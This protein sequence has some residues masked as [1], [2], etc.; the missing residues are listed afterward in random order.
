MRKKKTREY[1]RNKS[2]TLAKKIARHMANFKCA[3][4]GRGEPQLRTHGSHIFS[5]GVYKNMS[6]DID[7]ILCLCAGH[8]AIIP[9][10]NP[11]SWNW[12]AYPDQ[13]WEWFMAEYPELYQQ[14]K[15]RT[16]KIYKIDFEKKHERLKH[17]YKKLLSSPHHKDSIT[18]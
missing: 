5:E 1:W 12:H 4:C 15:L 14:L 13:S 11:G 2:V 8:H 18:N 17:L 16:Q 3:Y 9:G 6:A 10:R 7:N